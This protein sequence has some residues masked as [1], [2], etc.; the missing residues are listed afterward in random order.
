M[1]DIRVKQHPTLGILV[2]T[3]GHVMV[4]KCGTNPPHW[5][6]GNDNGRGY[7]TIMLYKSRRYIHRLIAET[8]IGEIPPN[9]EIDHIDRN[10]SNNALNNLRI[11]TDTANKLNTSR[12]DKCFKKY[13]TH[14]TLNKHKYYREKVKMWRKTR[15]AVRMANGSIKYLTPQ[16]A[17]E[18]LKLPVKQR[19][20]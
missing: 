11:V 5:T 1:S 14:L 10:P 19:I 17:T 20:M 12:S 18:L 3:D 4:P 8:F 16:K 2:C 6:T 7:K 9:M 15:K 13:G